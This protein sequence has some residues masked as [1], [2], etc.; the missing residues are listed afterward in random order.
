VLSNTK[1]DDLQG[2]Y[3][4]GVRNLQIL[5]SII[6]AAQFG[7]VLTIVPRVGGVASCESVLL[8]LQ[9]DSTSSSISM[10]L[11]AVGGVVLTSNNNAF[12]CW[13]CAAYCCCCKLQDVTTIGKLIR[14]VDGWTLDFSS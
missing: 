13:R 11:G 14:L 4:H 8:L 5:S 10:E 1:K 3:C 6:T 9:D 12:S 7:V 2:W